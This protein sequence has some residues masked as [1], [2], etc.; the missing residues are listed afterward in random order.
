[1][2]PSVCRFAQRFIRWVV[3]M[4]GLTSAVVNL[5]CIAH[6]AIEPPPVFD[7]LIDIS[8]SM[9]DPISL[10]RQ[11]ILSKSSKLAE[12]KKRLDRLCAELPEGHR[13]IVSVF[14][15]QRRELC[16]IVLRT[17]ADREK[18]TQAIASITSR[19]GSTFLWR[20]VDEE[21]TRASQLVSSTSQRARLIIYSDGD[22]MEKNASF[23]HKTV[24]DKHGNSIQKSLSLD[25]V[26]LGYDLAPTIKRDFEK[27]GANVVRA[28]SAEQLI[29]LH[30]DFCT[31]HSSIEL[32]QWLVVADMSNGLQIV[33][34]Q[35]DFGDGT[36]RQELSVTQGRFQNVRYQYR[37]PGTYVITLSTE[38]SSGQR[39]SSCRTITVRKRAWVMPVIR[40]DVKGPELEKPIRFFVDQ[41]DG[42]TLDWSLSDGSQ[43]NGT[44]MVWIPK[45][46]GKHSVELVATDESG[47]SKKQR[48]SF[49]VPTPTL[50]SLAIDLTRTSV[51]VGEPVTARAEPIHASFEY[52][53]TTDEKRITSGASTKLVFDQ[54][55]THEVKLNVKDAYGQTGTAT[56]FVTVVPPA[57]PKAI[58]RLASS[59]I[60]PGQ[61]LIAQNESSPT[62]S[63]FVW[64]LN[65]QPV[66]QDRHLEYAIPEQGRYQIELVAKDRFGQAHNYAETIEVKQ[67]WVEPV[68]VIR[69]ELR[70][71]KGSVAV[72]FINESRGDVEKCEL[73]PGDGSPIQ[74][75]QGA[76]DF[77]HTYGPGKWQPT[78]TVHG[79]KEAGHLPANWKGEPITVAKPTPRWIMSLLWQIPIGIGLAL[80]GVA[81][82]IALRR[83][84]ERH[85]SMRVFGH[86]TV[87]PIDDPLSV[88]N[89]DLDESQSEAQVSLPDETVLKITNL[90]N[91]YLDD[92]ESVPTEYEIEILRP[93][94]EVETQGRLREDEEVEIGHYV[95]TLST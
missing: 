75:V 9:N 82:V 22:D 36:P 68:A 89:F 44:S 25:W 83:R 37:R 6:D 46:P 58:F 79:T 62:A 71:Q 28:V 48:R 87:R 72:R 65:G 41:Q 77:V 69:M 91:G 66:S 53:W 80:C 11:P 15:H 17:P 67:K 45:Q 42:L 20:S 50:P 29:P 1:M 19:D 7:F 60:E 93:N 33:K 27:S 55:G 35:L 51:G 12:V 90:A 30:S 40:A 38:T 73:D 59:Q 95:L 24:L 21:L 43:A 78:V 70:Y 76:G 47:E 5:P 8:G 57:P 23:T 2:S 14:D 52:A 16:D 74:T 31:S 86:L 81:S 10:A 61:R 63:G 49:T 4:L 3:L 88:Y 64:R 84:K 32:G 39:D 54:P 85:E 13:V 94:L 56:A 92:G 34:Q 26:T 18:L